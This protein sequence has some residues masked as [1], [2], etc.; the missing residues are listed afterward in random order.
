MAGRRGRSELGKGT[1]TRYGSRVTW[2]V[3]SCPVYW[4]GFDWD[5][6]ICHTV[7][8]S[9]ERQASIVRPPPA[10]SSCAAR[11]PVPLSQVS[12][13]HSRPLPFPF[14]L[15]FVFVFLIR[16]PPRFTLFFSSAAS[17]LYKRQVSRPPWFPFEWTIHWQ[18]R[19]QERGL[20]ETW[21]SVTIV[22]DNRDCVR[23]MYECI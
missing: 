22:N 2:P 5:G 9:A 20:T 13:E 4:H 10:G 11:R 23:L 7:P 14:R 12:R 6:V 18:T 17:E 1:G 19:Y 15:V 16:D 21:C 8:R 3:M